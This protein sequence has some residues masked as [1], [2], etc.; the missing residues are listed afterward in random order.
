MGTGPSCF[1]LPK[2]ERLHGRKDI[3]ELLAKGR[4]RVCRS[5]KYCVRKGNSLPY[6]R[7]MVSVSKRFFKRAVKRNLLKRRIRESYRLQKRLPGTEG[8]SDIM[9]IYGTKEILPFKEI[10]ALV[11]QVIGKAGAK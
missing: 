5:M 7:I 3:A 8:G 2:D 11:G 4:F 1:G 10:Y 6:S 9:F